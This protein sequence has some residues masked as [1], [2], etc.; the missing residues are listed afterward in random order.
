[1]TQKIFYLILLL[2][3]HTIMSKTT[4]I[5]NAKVYQFNTHDK[6][7]F[8]SAILIEDN[9]IKKVGDE[10]EI[11]ENLSKDTQIIDAK[12]R[13]ILPGI[14]ES[15]AHFM[16]FGLSMSRLRLND[17]K[18]LEGALAA[19][20][21]FYQSKPWK[22][23]EWVFGEGWDQNNWPGKKWP[24][25]KDLD[26]LE[27]PH[28]IYLERTDGHAGW[29][30]SQALK[31]AKVD[32]N[33]SDPQGGKVLK[34]KNGEP[35]GILIDHAMNFITTL[36]PDETDQ[37]KETA[38]YHAIQKAN[39]LGITILTDAGTGRGS[40]EMIQKVYQE[41]ENR[42]LRLFL[43]VRGGDKKFSSEMLEHGPIKN[44]YD[45]F[46][47]FRAFKF[48]LDG[49]LGSRGAS[50]L[51]PYSDDPKNSGLSMMD[52]NEF[53]EKIKEPL[54]KGF[55][56]GVHT[57]GDR[58]NKLAID[59]FEELNSKEKTVNENVF[60]LEHAQILDPSD[61][62]RMKK[63]G[64]IASMQPIHCTSD[65]PWVH[66][67]L[68]QKRSD[69]RAYIWKSILKHHIK[70]VFGSD[71]PVEP[72]N[73]WVGFYAAITRKDYEHPEKQGWNVKETLTR[74]EA[75]LAYTLNGA[76]AMGLENEIGNLHEG[77]KADLIIL[78]RDLMTVPE[79]EIPQIKVLQ[80]MVDGRWV[81]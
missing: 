75:L 22:K 4:F 25:K 23:D 78:D 77:R 42:K 20:K 33:T 76:R 7:I 52:K 27:I 79:N 46:I 6:L 62:P 63:L 45:G 61:L 44:A 19:V 8:H 12:G 30:N 72:I 5:K 39:E 2:S 53:I 66:E 1:M 38:I 43:M 49:A 28:P 55:Q 51:E 81:H 32:K 11:S 60:R 26:Q 31:I 59:V 18:S 17:A 80:T 47:Q 56:I 50:L 9:K 13:A 16:S 69:E 34:D 58:A 71:A 36:I 73:P 68:G 29:V 21:K 67:R 41:K 57:I 54:R 48:F 40:W 24:S 37:E 65:M 35:T 10:K 3:T 64:I 15:H 70:L 14:I 74:E